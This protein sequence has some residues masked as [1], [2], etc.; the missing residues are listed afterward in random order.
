MNRIHIFSIAIVLSALMAFS[1]AAS[2]ARGRVV[3]ADNTIKTD[4]GTLIRGAR[5]SLDIWDETPSQADI[6]AMK[7]RGLNA[8]HIYAEF[9][10]SNRPGGYNVAKVDN[11]VNL[12]EKNDL[13]VILTIGCGGANGSF[14]RTFVEQFWNFYA[15]RY[16]DKTHVIY[17]VMNE[18]QAWSAPYNN[19]TLDMEKAAYQ[20]IRR[21]APDTHIMMMSYSQPNNYDAAANESANLGISWANA[22]VAFHTYG[23]DNR[24]DNVLTGFFNAM[25]RKGI[26]Y[27]C[28]EP[29]LTLKAIT[30]KIFERDGV[31]E[32]HFISVHDIASDKGSFD[33]WINANGIRWTSD[34]SSQPGCSPTAIASYLQVNGGSWQQSSNVTVNSGDTVKIGPQPVTGGSWSWSGGGTSGSARE[35]TLHPTSSITATATYTNSCGATSSQKFSI[36]VNGGGGTNG[37]GGADK[38]VHLSKRNASGFAI[39]GNNGGASGQEV[40]LWT[41]DANNANQAWVEMDRGQGFYSYKKANTDFCID[42]GNGGANGQSVILWACDAS[43]QNQQWEKIDA[44][45]GNYRLQKRNASG[46]SID[47][48]N[49][50]ADGQGLYLWASD[51]TNQNQ[52][53]SFSAG[54]A[55]AGNA[56]N[57]GS[58]GGAGAVQSGHVYKLQNANSGKVLG[59]LSMSTADGAKALQWR[60]NGARDHEWRIDL[61]SSGS[62][63]LTNMNSGKVLAVLNMSTSDGGEVIQWEDNGT[64]DHEWKVVGS[65]GGTFKLVNRN[66]GKVLGIRDMSKDDGGMALQ[67]ADTGAP[68]HDWKLIDVGAANGAGGGGNQ[69]NNVAN[70]T[71]QVGISGNGSTSVSAGS[72]SYKSGTTVTITATPAQGSVFSGWSGAFT[73]NTNPLTITMN[74]NKSLT[75]MFMAQSNNN[76]NGNPVTD[77]LKTVASFPIGVAVNAGGENNSIVSSGTSAQQQAVVFKHF[78]QMTAGNIMKMS[79]LHPSEGNF[80]FGQADD[81]VSLARAHGLDIHGH[82]LIWHA[83]YQVPGFMKNYG[84]D[85]A[86]MLKNHIQNIVTHFQGRVVSWDVVNEALADDGEGTVGNGLRSTVFSQKM[87]LNFIDQAFI[88]ARAADSNVDLFYNDYNTEA[89]GQKTRNL[90]ALVDGMRSRGV[91]IT[92]VG[93]QMHVSIDWPSISAIE[94]SMKA[95]AD[96]GLKVKIS[97]LDVGMRNAYN[98]LTAEAAARQKQRYHDI[99]AAYMRVVPPAQ[100]AGITVWGV[101]DSDSWINQPGKPDWPLLFDANFQAKPALQGFGNALLGK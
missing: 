101:W 1:T 25:K 79:Y 91:P 84:G 56:A 87:G 29:N 32:T 33:D 44:G 35:Q 48:R 73:G 77:G 14:N 70:Y 43:N 38:I 6:D 60:D 46:Y 23:I 37:G 94:A 50:G 72:H 58:A 5:V 3:V 88:N 65:A 20:L 4:I 24:E 12:A 64:A 11:V 93:F 89:N 27:A 67:W 66:S 40:Y 78:D 80:T 97:E 54:S 85:F 39:D 63:K 74:G 53:W 28:T 82:T 92:G 47:G 36:A 96:R 19:A 55:N 68:D 61:L 9:A 34:F 13:Y 90:V 21:Y 75:A 51:A 95:I 22:S 30:T 71:L 99:V 100:R 62:Y 8:F 15:P 69:N 42:G 83:D 98:S 17:E 31:S 49:G 45:S 16:K 59:V 52:Q 18:P 86:A 57:G 81:L 41:N 7:S 2:A 76:G 10:D 26:A